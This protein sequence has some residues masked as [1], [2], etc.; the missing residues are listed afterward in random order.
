MKKKS[1]WANHM[2]SFGGLLLRIVTGLIFVFAGYNKLFGTGGLFDAGSSATFVGMLSWLGATAIIFAWI[3]AIIEFIGGILLIAGLFDEYVASF[4][5]FIILV[6]II[7]VHW[8]ASAG[9]VALWNGIKYQ[10]LLLVILFKFIDAEGCCGILTFK[11]LK[12]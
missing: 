10:L 1:W 6:A 8:D 4:L 5:T 2:D 9:F 12:F 3:V 11:K 7:T